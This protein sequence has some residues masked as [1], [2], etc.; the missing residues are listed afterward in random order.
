[1]LPENWAK[2]TDHESYEA[3]SLMAEGFIHCSFENQIEAVLERYFSNVEKVIIL[4]LETDL[5]T[6]KLVV[7]PST[8]GE[9]YPHIYGKI[10]RKAIVKI[11]ERH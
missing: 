6:E 9:L 11:E 7:E 4:H 1:M 2:F 8:N 10:N 3:D 5:L